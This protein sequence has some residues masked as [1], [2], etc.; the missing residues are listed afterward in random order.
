MSRSLALTVGWRFYRARQSNKFISFIAFASTA[1]IAL[2]VGVLIVLL[3]AM[4]GFEKAL[5]ERLL[6]VTPHA[7]LIGVN[8]PIDDWQRLIDD[9]KKIPGIAAAAPFMKINGLVQKK[10]GFQA[11]QLVGIDTQLE[12]AVSTLPQF[13]DK[14]SWNSL[15]P[16]QG[17][18]V[19][20]GRSLLKKLNLEIGDTLALYV[21]KQVSGSSSNFASAKSH[22]FVI[23]GTY[24][25][26]GELESTTAYIP[27]DY[28]Q[29]LQG[30][31]NEVSGVRLKMDDV[32]MAPRLVRQLG[33]SQ[34]QIVNMLDW[35]RTQGH[36]YQDIQLV[37]LVMYLALAL[38]IAVACF[39]VVSTLVMS[40]RDKQSEIA[41]L[42]TMGLS[43]SSVMQV[44]MVQGTLNGII[45]CSIGAFI[46]VI[47]ALN[48]SALAK[49]IEELFNVQIISGDVYFIDF[50]PSELQ[51]NDVYISVGLAL[52]MSLLSTLY[53][54][55]K[56]TKVDPAET[57]SG[58]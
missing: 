40:V 9:A 23:T 27:M 6:G 15:G 28:S 57:L 56:A 51:W 2:G 4:N 32:F 12:G 22:R 7:E 34:E 8:A 36:V 29:S 46:G 20:V 39:N 11:I 18:H 30:F 53:P 45:G 58:G 1:G 43:R 24:T 14:V 31:G 52:A 44:F 38:V 3:S 25:L 54:A 16:K 35:T 17:N 48:L 41:I 21:P 26:G 55:W 47:L 13:T 19:I 10:G 50:L 5:E 42:I 37:R 33:Y 49:Q